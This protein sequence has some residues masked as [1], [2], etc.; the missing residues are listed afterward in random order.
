M[1][2]DGCGRPVLYQ[3]AGIGLPRRIDWERR[4]PGIA[5]RASPRSLCSLFSRASTPRT[6]S[7]PRNL[8]QVLVGS[9]LGRK[10]YD[11]DGDFFPFALRTDWKRMCSRPNAILKAVH[12]GRIREERRSSNRST[13]LPGR[14][15]PSRLKPLRH[16]SSGIHPAG[17]RSPVSQTSVRLAKGWHGW[18]LEICPTCALSSR[19]G[20]QWGS[21]SR[22]LATCCWRSTIS[23]NPSHS[24]EP[25]PK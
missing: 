6:T 15:H 5:G 24:P 25:L 8:G 22:L 9:C 19:N 16:F 23:G 21:Q 17:E 3:H 18:V 13:I 1:L 4:A 7:D 14:S 2:Q 11:A 20:P 12:A 10:F